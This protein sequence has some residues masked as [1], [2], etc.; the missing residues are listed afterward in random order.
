[1]LSR[2]LQVIWAIMA[3]ALMTT[4]A[5]GYRTHQEAQRVINSPDKLVVNY[6]VEVL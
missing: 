4:A 3:I 2:I 1:M 6:K 5:L